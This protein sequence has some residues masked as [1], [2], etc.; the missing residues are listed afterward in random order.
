M[1]KQC[2]IKYCEKDIL[3]V[4]KVKAYVNGKNQLQLSKTC[5]EAKYIGRLLIKV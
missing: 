1:L 2:K 5:A 3:N 4:H